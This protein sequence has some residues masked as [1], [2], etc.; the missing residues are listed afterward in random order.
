RYSAGSCPAI[1]HGLTVA[2]FMILTQTMPATRLIGTCAFTEGRRRAASPRVDA[3][4]PR[5]DVGGP[6]AC[7]D[8]VHQ[9]S[10]RIPDHRATHAR[11][12]GRAG[13]CGKPRFDREKRQ[14]PP[15]LRQ[16]R[17]E[18]VP[19]RPHPTLVAVHREAALIAAR[20]RQIDLVPPNRTQ[21]LVLGTSGGGRY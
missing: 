21:D 14:M 5:P 13:L 10:L 2:D 7:V 9:P 19:R 6:P 18:L 15:I 1:C 16:S 12:L 8:R 20:A 17:E 4:R 11:R 3:P